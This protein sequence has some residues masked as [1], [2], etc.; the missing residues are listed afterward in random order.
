MRT[1]DIGDIDDM[2]LGAT[3][4]GTGGGG[5]PYIAKLMVKQAIETWPISNVVDP[6]D[7]PQDGLVMTSA[8]IGAPTVILE[9]T[10]RA[11]SSSPAVKAMARYKG[12][13]PVALM[14]IEAGGMNTLVPLAIAGELGL[15]VIDADSMRRAFPQIEMT[16]FTLAGISAAPLAVADEKGNL[17]IFETTTNQ[18]AE[19]LARGAVITLGLANAITCYTMTA[20]QIAKHGIH[21]SML[22]HGPGASPGRPSSAVSG[23]IREVPRVRGG[24]ARLQRQDRG[25]R[26][27]HHQG[28]RARHGDPG[29]RHGPDAR[30]AHRDPERVP[31]RFENDVPVLTVPDLISTLD[32][33][34]ATPITT[35]TLAYGSGWRSSACPAPPSGTSPAGSTSWAPGRSAMTSSTC[36]SETRPDERDPAPRHRRRR[37][38]HRRGRGGRR[39]PSSPRSRS[40]PRRS[41]SRHPIGHRGRRRTVD[42]SRITQAMLG[43]THPA[44]AIVERRGLY[45][46]GILRLAARAHSVKPGYRLAGGLRAAHHGPHDHRPR[47]LRV[48]R[49][50]DRAAGPEENQALRG[51]G[52]GNVKA[53]A[54]S[55]AFSPANFDQEFRA[56]EIL[57]AELGD[58]VAISLSR[59]VGSLGLLEREDAT[60]L[61]AAL[62]SVSN[63]VVSGLAKALTDNG[64]AVTAYLTQNDGTLMGAEQ[65]VKFPIL[66]VGSGPTN[67]MRGACVLAGLQ[68]ALVIDVGGTSS[69]VGILVSGFPREVATAV[70]V[71]G[72]RTN[73][74]MPDLISIGLGG[75]TIVRGE[76]AEVKVGPDSV[77]YRVVQDALVMGGSVPTLSDVSVKGGRLSGFGDAGLLGGMT[78]ATA[79]AALRWVDERIQ[80]L[81]DRMKASRQALPLIAVGGGSHSWP[82]TCRASRRSSPPTTSRS[83][84]RSARPSRRRR[85]RSTASTGTRS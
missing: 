80:T 41:R 13:D 67:S 52:A 27:A 29:A 65:A 51:R 74:R 75:G 12:Q 53:I 45:R 73:F 44:N 76:D 66:T 64:L 30:D 54:V 60:A 77:G 1:I 82:S 68:D 63:A 7:L 50:R 20:A 71:G 10:P 26:P 4:L 79:E 42:R 85:V 47:G 58:S 55:C 18:V 39:A 25:H 16:T 14:A 2:A 46:V 78:E 48:R 28:L 22:L 23:R 15:P 6:R 81:C 21:G 19:T 43:T 5:D 24:Q 35:E 59:Q 36:P 70:E 34:T 62:L 32:N 37:H 38:Q 61:N 83:R 49:P 33:E 8:V 40:P 17:C 31:G 56:E 84:T 9:K 57:R 11:R 69:D 72:V 3:L